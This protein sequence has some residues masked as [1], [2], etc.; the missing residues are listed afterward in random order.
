MGGMLLKECCGDGSGP[1]KILL[2]II[3][4]VKS[5]VENILSANVSHPAPGS[6]K[7]CLAASGVLD[8]REPRTI[9]HIIYIS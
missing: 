4:V 6:E 2:A 1:P 8:C 5:T 3:G 7:G 9:N